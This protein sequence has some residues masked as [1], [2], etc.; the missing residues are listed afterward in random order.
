LVKKYFTVI[1][2]II[3]CVSFSFNNFTLGQTTQE[4]I[5][6]WIEIHKIVMVDQIENPPEA[7]WIDWHY[8]LTVKCDGQSF[9]EEA[10]LNKCGYEKIVDN[11]YKFE[12]YG[13]HVRINMDLFDEDMYS[14]PDLADIS[15]HP[16]GGIDNYD[17]FTLGTRFTAVYDAR[18]N[19][20]MDNDDVTMVSGFYI[21]SGEYDGSYGVDENDAELWFSIWD[22][23][24][25]PKAEAGPDRYCY[26]GK[27]F[28]L[29][30]T[31][32]MASNA[33]NIVEYEWDFDGDGEFEA[34]GVEPSYTF[35]TRGQYDV[36]LRVWDSFG[37]A[38]IDTCEINVGDSPP[39][40]SFIFSPERPNLLSPVRFHD[41]S[42]DNDG[43]I[44]SWL[45]DFGDG[46]NSTKQNPTHT[47]I[48]KGTYNVVLIVTDNTGELNASSVE[49]NVV[50]LAPTADFSFYPNEPVEGD[51]VYFRDASK[52]PDGVIV[53]IEWDFGDGY[54]SNDQDPTHNY[55]D[56]GVYSV[57]LV[58]SDEDGEMNTVTKILRVLQKHDLILIVKDILGLTLSNAEIKV[59]SND[60]C[61]ASG[62]TDE[63]GILFLSEMPEGLYEIRANNLGMTTSKFCPLTNS[64]TVQILM[65]L[66][67]YTLGSAGCLTVFVSILIFY[68][69]KRK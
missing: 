6:L 9:N 7:E 41:E 46:Q 18:N 39:L 57:R 65:P 20:L 66:S 67:Y 47:Y 19:M 22:N 48:E 58:A 8:Y 4:K 13:R 68:L 2:L 42:S 49:V 31:G 35:S 5:T 37:E 11:V 12:I 50:N 28:S 44:K 61:V 56:A 63:K 38:D 64:A 54:A 36:C 24:D 16:G 14:R 55:R 45:W 30:G 1:F 15:S 21:T 53:E 25:I 17:E 23:Y 69:I 51:D 52:D 27:K 34:K 29:D 62:A 10:V 26:T 59:Y 60:E 43:Y 32:S 3:I 40:I 33:S